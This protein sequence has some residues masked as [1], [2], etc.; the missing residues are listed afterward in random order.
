MQT[1]H[2]FFD[3]DRTLW[4]FEKNSKEALRQI[5]KS[6]ELDQIFPDFPT[7]LKHYKNI[8]QELWV[9]YGKGNIT[10][11]ELRILRFQKT[12]LKHGCSDNSLIEKIAQEY[13]TVSPRQKQL[14]P[15][16]IETLN[17]LKKDGYPMHIITNG[18]KEV[19][20]IKLKESGLVDFFDHVLC[21]ETVGK[22]K[23]HPSV[24]EHALKLANC[25]PAQGVM[26]GDDYQVDYLGALRVGMKALFFNYKG[27]KRMRKDDDVIEQLS[28]IPAKIPWLFR[29]N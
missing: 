29:P 15:R 6:N 5:F 12:F 22:T 1:I 26:I 27:E 24:F 13:I 9:R 7:F 21:S 19:Q 20:H 8:N 18:F 14:F 2:L 17:A 10:K 25:S 23:P 16:A 28:E 3:L 4:D 11:E